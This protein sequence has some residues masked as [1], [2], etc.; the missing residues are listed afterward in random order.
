MAFYSRQ[1]C[2][3]AHPVRWPRGTIARFPHLRLLDL[4]RLQMD[5]SDDAD[6][7]LGSKAYLG[8][9]HCNASAAEAWQSAAP[10]CLADVPATT[11]ATMIC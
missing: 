11:A 7:L 8:L 5:G 1:Q 10:H 3:T 4:S 6:S 2:N 9:R